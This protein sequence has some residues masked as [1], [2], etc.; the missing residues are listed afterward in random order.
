M[1]Y[2]SG[3]LFLPL[4]VVLLPPSQQRTFPVP[5]LHYP[6]AQIPPERF[7]LFFCNNLVPFLLLWTLS[8]FAPLRFS[9]VLEGGSC[10]GR[11]R[12]AQNRRRATSPLPFTMRPLSSLSQLK[13][14]TWQV[15]RAM[16]LN[17]LTGWR[18]WSDERADVEAGRS[19]EGI[20]LSVWYQL[21]GSYS[22]LEHLLP[23]L[24]F[25]TIFEC[26]EEI[27]YFCPEN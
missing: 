18:D 20:T 26:F 9:E 15:Q 2:S 21:R 1:A 27:G 19:D 25:F 22:K 24:W 4:A 8:N 13:I 7:L 10:S 12:H 5:Q 3:R 6:L 14:G 23:T 11:V 16:R 17:S